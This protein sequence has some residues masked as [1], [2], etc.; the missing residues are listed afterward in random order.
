M[1]NC[2]LNR[3]IPAL[4][5]FIAVAAATAVLFSVSSAAPQQAGS[6]TAIHLI[7]VEP[8][9]Y[10]SVS[11]QDD[12]R[13]IRRY[14]QGASWE[15]PISSETWQQLRPLGISKIRLINVESGSAVQFEAGK[16]GPQFNFSSLLPGLQD[17]RNYG[18]RP[19][20]IVGQGPQI[21]LVIQEDGSS[22]GVSD[23]SRYEEYAY[24][25]L[26][27]VMVEQGFSQADFEVANEPDINGAS[28][29][30][31]EKLPMG[32]QAMYE[33]Y[34]Q[35]YRAWA[36]AADQLIRE[37]P[38]LKLRIGGPSITPH[39]FSFGKFNWAEHFAKD[40]AAQKLR[41]DFFSYHFYG[42]N[43]A[44]T[45]L[46]T[47]GRSPSFAVQIDTIRNSLSTAGL[48]NVPIY[49]TEWGPSYVTTAIPE[50]I[51]NGNQVGA[52]WTARFFM[53]MAASKIDEGMA[54][55]LRDHFDPRRLENGWAWPSFLLSD[56]VTPKGLYNVALMFSK[57]PG[58]RVRA[59]DAEGS[60]G[61]L[62]SADKSKLGVLAFNQDWD[63]S[64]S[65]ERAITERM[66]I[67]ISGL[68]FPAARVRVVRYLVDATHS[69]AYHFYQQGMPIDQAN[70]GLTTVEEISLP[71][72]AGVVTLP[73]VDLAPSSVTL[74]EISA[75]RKS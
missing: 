18:L 47:F 44:L 8:G 58:Q 15:L 75:E 19:H 68:P 1:V 45:G 42:N 17:C 37:H 14:F 28:W 70:V 31:P 57:L 65:K 26:K 23:W 34:F 12:L 32:A 62:A 13:L 53:E 36:T 40:V 52:A 49:L 64:N 4:G 56:G 9:I 35:L 3:A 66:E 72:I 27:F 60:I 39:T 59:S 61:V 41:L 67:R 54:L 71:V 24:A 51:I 22:Y 63:Y 69:N 16:K 46:P 29:L 11:G 50:G 21:A 6:E 30:T 73:R 55:T 25:F 5:S 2:E 74:W 33:A 20:I 38:E 48:G 7:T 10:H 43:A